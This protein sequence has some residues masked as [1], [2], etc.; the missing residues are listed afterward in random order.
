[1]IDWRDLLA[2]IVLV[3][4]GTLVVAAISF[5]LFPASVA[6][7]T[8]PSQPPAAVPVPVPVLLPFVTESQP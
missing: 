6:V 7:P 5:A 3:V 4:L 2:L 1:M 8:F